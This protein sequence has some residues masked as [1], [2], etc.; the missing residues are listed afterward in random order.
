MQYLKSDYFYKKSD[1]FLKKAI[2][3][4]IRFRE[5]WLKVELCFF[6][7]EGRHKSEGREEKTHF[8]FFFSFKNSY[9]CVVKILV[10]VPKY[11][12]LGP[13]PTKTFSL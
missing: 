3:N 6:F 12:V 2:T 7:R 10:N 13:C 11:Y 9:L 1:Y 8:D 4:D 5:M